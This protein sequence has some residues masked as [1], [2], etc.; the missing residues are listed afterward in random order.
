MG[1][2]EVIESTVYSRGKPSTAEL[3]LVQAGRKNLYLR[4]DAAMDYNR[5]RAAAVLSDVHLKL[6][7][8]FREMAH[9]EI[10]YQK[11]LTDYSN[12]EEATR[13]KPPTKTADDKPTPVAR[14]G[15]SNHQSGVAIDVQRA[16][17][18]NLKTKEYDSPTDLWLT[19][20]AKTY[21]FYRT[22]P[23]EPWHFDH[24]IKPEEKVA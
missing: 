1:A 21:N 5:M 24:I 4:K 20:N 15:Y 10:L 14:P 7:S 17:G 6:N 18:D 23:R 8:A 11:Y 22:V 2:P 12:W 9:Q 19:A 3:Y 13:A 16:D